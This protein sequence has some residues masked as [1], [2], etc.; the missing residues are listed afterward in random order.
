MKIFSISTILKT[1]KGKKMKNKHFDYE[2]WLVVLGLLV[3]GCSSGS[4]PRISIDPKADQVLRHMSDTLAQHPTFGFTASDYIDK[5]LDTG[6]TVRFFREIDIQVKRPNR[7]YARI[8]GDAMDRTIW[9]AQDTLT[10]L[11]NLK[12]QYAKLKVPNRI[13]DMFDFIMEE[14]GLTVPVADLLF[15]NPYA[16]LT[17]SIR[18]GVYQGLDKVDSY[19]CHHLSFQQEYI[20]WQ[21]WIDAGE[22]PVP[23]KILIIHTS[24]PGQPRYCITL[25]NWNLRANLPEKGFQANLPSRAKSVPLETVLEIQE[26]E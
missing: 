10:V 5:R 12:I 20:D 13:D 8:L 4:S 22:S 17:E 19:S 9:Y 14:Y 2:V 16:I 6:Q 26:R 25:K 15:E 23:R 24:D 3:G 18:T 7:I 1:Y 11:D 21:I